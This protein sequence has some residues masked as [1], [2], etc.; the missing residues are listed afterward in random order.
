[1][2]RWGCVG[3]GTQAATDDEVRGFFASVVRKKLGLTLSSRIADG[4]RVYHIATPK[5]VKSRSKPNP[6]AEMSAR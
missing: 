6:P 4:V 1:M 3:D 5:P 2:P